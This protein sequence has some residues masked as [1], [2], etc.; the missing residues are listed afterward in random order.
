MTMSIPERIGAEVVEHLRAARFRRV[1][2]MFAP[3]LQALIS[4]EK[5]CT[6]WQSVQEKYGTVV[7]ADAP[8]GTE[9]SSGTAV[10]VPMRLT[11][12]ELWVELVV[13]DAGHLAGLRLTPPVEPWQ[14]PDYADPSAFDE[15][16]MALDADPLPVPATVTVPRRRGSCPA[17]VLL[18][19]GGPFDRDETSG[20]NKPLKDI[21]WGLAS[22]G[23]AVLRFDKITHTHP[24]R[25]DETFTATDEY[26]PYAAA[27]VRALRTHAAVAAD[28]VFVL[29][30]SM[31]GKFAPRVAATEPAVAG[32]ITMAA[33]AQPMQWAAVRVARYLAALT[34]GGETAARQTLENLTRQAQ[35]VDSPDLSPATPAA[36]LPLGYSAAYWLDLRAYDPVATAAAL[37]KPMLILQGGRDYQVTVNDDLSL[38]QAALGDRPEVTIRI[39]TADNHLF[40][41]GTGPST[42]AEYLAPQHVDH[43]VITDIAAWITT[44]HTP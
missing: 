6:A 33:D 12:G 21:A 35:S 3:P 15:Y 25:L 4:V 24:E 43:H 10:R 11:D 31:G 2:E 20:S 39:Y 44:S 41:P 36:D 16:D 26:V 34:P 9:D 40:F 13:D 14:P 19:G 38:W 30:H 27:A 5:L 22:R 1:H 37:A 18:A 28:R 29:G 32:L 7:D 42:P 8:T 23:I 17:V